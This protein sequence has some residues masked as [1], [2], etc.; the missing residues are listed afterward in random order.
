[1]KTGM[2]V[3]LTVLLWGGEARAHTGLDFPVELPHACH[4]MDIILNG[5]TTIA[6]CE[7]GRWSKLVEPCLAMMEAAMRGIDWWLPKYMED[8]SLT[9]NVLRAPSRIALEQWRQ[10]KLEC[11]GNP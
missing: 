3:L 9:T 1:M 8:G 10:A 2:F 7:D 4:N 11:W 6:H 5:G